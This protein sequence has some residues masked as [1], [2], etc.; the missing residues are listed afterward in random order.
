MESFVSQKLPKI[1]QKSFFSVKNYQKLSKNYDDQNKSNI[2]DITDIFLVNY[3]QIPTILRDDKE[4]VSVMNTPSFVS[5]QLEFL[6]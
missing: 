6:L 3:Q 4:G 1:I 2:T 5:R